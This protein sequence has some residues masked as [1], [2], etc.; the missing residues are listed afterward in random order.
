MKK[1]SIFVVASLFLLAGVLYA[2]GNAGVSEASVFA[3]EIA[4]AEGVEKDDERKKEARRGC[5][6]S[7]AE[8]KG[9]CG[10]KAESS[11]TSAEKKEGC[12]SSK[13]GESGA[14]ASAEAKSAA[15]KQCCDSRKAARGSCGGS[16]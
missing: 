4:S 13:K 6:S 14:S 12:C 5:C 9:S 11:C 1:S 7:R 3:A 10:S 2:A 8:A 15:S 16:R